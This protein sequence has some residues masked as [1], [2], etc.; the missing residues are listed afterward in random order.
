MC[1][2]ALAANTPYIRM[3]SSTLASYVGSTVD[4]YYLANDDTM[5]HFTLT[6]G[7]FNSYVSNVYS[8]DNTYALA[9]SQIIAADGYLPSDAKLVGNF[10]P[11]IDVYW[12]VHFSNV[13]Y[14]DSAAFVTRATA[15]NKT[16]IFFTGL[17]N[18]Y[19]T[20]NYWTVGANTSSVGSLIS[21]TSGA[22]PGYFILNNL[23]S[24]THKFCARFIHYLGDPIDFY[25]GIAHY[26]CVSYDNSGYIQ[27]GITCP[28]INSDYV[29]EGNDEIPSISDDPQVP[30]FDGDAESVGS[31]SGTISENSSGGQD[32][33]ITV[34]TDNTGLVGSLL[35]GIKNLFVPSSDFLN[36]WHSDIEDA[37]S[38]HLGGVSEAVSLIDEQ[39]DYLRAATS[40]QYIY[41][42]QL[43]LPIGSTGYSN[44]VE[45]IGADYTLI[46]GRQ[47][48]LRP[49]R[50]G[51]LKI[52]WDFLEFA[53]DVVCVLAVLNMLQTK[54]EIFLNPDGEV[55]TYDN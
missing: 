16:N 12:N 25:L 14:F 44:G 51:S 19:A 33:N 11:V 38:E 31:A 20:S 6:V 28:A 45:T 35:S 15:M 52:L 10:Y 54:F 36:D 29:F 8:Q 49:A 13:T 39:A 37:F 32:I 55:I 4:A 18:D 23:S 46:E 48:E 3:T 26:S 22:N 42:P 47:V 30:S 21:S 5:K 24:S 9:S 27:V 17:W 34:Q 43:T 2:N 53:V 1:L 41:F 50:T 7:T 40:A